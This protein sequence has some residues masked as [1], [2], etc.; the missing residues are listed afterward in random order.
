MAI[1]RI[2]FPLICS[3]LIGLKIDTT[4]PTLI[5]VSG[6]YQYFDES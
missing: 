4:L 1:T 5:S 6:V 3:G 2:L